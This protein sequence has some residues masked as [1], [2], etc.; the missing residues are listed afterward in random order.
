[1]QS[2]IAKYS[3]FEEQVISDGPYFI[4]I[5]KLPTA[6]KTHRQYREAKTKAARKGAEIIHIEEDKSIVEEIRHKPTKEVLRKRK[7][8]GLPIRFNNNSN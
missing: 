3:E 1:M 7:V 5:R 4:I 8:M 6:I 2:F